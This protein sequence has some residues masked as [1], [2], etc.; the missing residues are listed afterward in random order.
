MSKKDKLFGSDDEDDLDYNPEDDLHVDQ[1]PS[2]PQ[3][4]PAQPM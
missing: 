2:A 1:T 3:P 4:I